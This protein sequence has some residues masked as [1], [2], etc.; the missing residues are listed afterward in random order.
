MAVALFALPSL[1]DTTALPSA[2]D[3]LGLWQVRIEAPS[4][5]L[6]GQPFEIRLHVS[7]AVSDGEA[8]EYRYRFAGEGYRRAGELDP[9]SA[10]LVGPED[11]IDRPLPD[12]AASAP[13]DPDPPEFLRRVTVLPIYWLLQGSLHELVNLSGEG[14]RGAPDPQVRVDGESH[15][16]TRTFT[17]ERPGEPYRVSYR[18]NVEY[19]VSYRD[20]R[21]ERG[22]GWWSDETRDEWHASLDA[23]A[24]GLC[25]PSPE[26][27]EGSSTGVVSSDDAGEPGSTA[28]FGLDG[29]H[30]F[31]LEG[32]DRAVVGVPF[33]VTLDLEIERRTILT[34]DEDGNS[35]R[36]SPV[37]WEASIPDL[38]GTN[39]DPTLYGD[40]DRIR[41]RIGRGPNIGVEPVTAEFRCTTA[42]APYLIGT[43]SL[44]SVGVVY[45][46]HGDGPRIHRREQYTPEPDRIWTAGDCVAPEDQPVG[47]ED[48]EGRIG[49]A[50]E[51]AVP[52]EGVEPAE[53]E[54]VGFIPGGAPGAPT[55]V[56]VI[57]DLPG[58]GSLFAGRAER[59]S[60]VQA[61]I[62]E[63]V[64]VFIKPARVRMREDLSRSRSRRPVEPAATL[65]LAG[66]AGS[67]R[68]L[69]TVLDASPVVAKPRT[70]PELE[71]YLV[72]T[73]QAT[74]D[75][76]RLHVL[77]RG[78]ET[79]ELRTE[80][81]VL[82]PLDLEPDAERELRAR[83]A[84]LA[85]EGGVTVPVEGYCLEML[86]EPPAEG[87]LF[88][89]A[90]PR[91][92][93]GF[94]TAER[95]LD[96][97][98]LVAESGSLNPDMDAE[99]Y[100]HA[101]TQ[102]AMWTAQQGFDRDAFEK[103]FVGRTRTTIE[104]AGRDWSESVDRAVRELVPNRWQDI[105]RILESAGLAD[106]ADG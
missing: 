48:G 30:R 38:E 18:G 32:P 82:E 19:W 16:I 8:R 22:D 66:G 47:E 29:I 26:D 103:A 17:C 62:S 79:V 78:E 83:L 88:R 46:I 12:W 64:H 39:T 85:D 44:P 94:P 87:Q 56:P 20:L 1:L 57:S 104:E 11:E 15:T 71:A 93:Q 9:E 23:D 6:A 52:G 41:R 74:G 95:V 40:R 34:L 99:S 2:T 73:G 92:R 49:A 37:L 84:S 5:A 13:R 60:G 7:R 55:G 77:N 4:R 25:V 101:V 58:I 21:V 10:A 72:G 102:W 81:M 42:G 80:A 14:D 97:A 45:R 59:A 90:P 50:S 43:S 91:V 68:E 27:G 106:G 100:R 61:E 89:L 35:V 53:D 96:A 69:G 36:L 31:T 76:F 86:A 67:I 75:A 33:E 105:Q 3:D 98:R 51:P 24:A 28:T 70:R 54:R 63:A 65:A